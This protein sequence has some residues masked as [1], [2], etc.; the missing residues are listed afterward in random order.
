VS[1]TQSPNGMVM[2][3]QEVECGEVEWS[4]KTEHV[5]NKQ[6]RNQNDTK[7]VGK[8]MQKGIL[9]KRSRAYHPTIKCV[10]HLAAPRPWHSCWWGP[11][12][13]APAI[14]KPPHGVGWVNP[15][16]FVWER[17]V[18]RDVPDLE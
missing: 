5:R 16:C 14:M 9:T 18:V 3:S 15:P 11:G 6:T 2:A 13:K 1:L 7:I 10:V 4:A 17:R 8:H 12:K